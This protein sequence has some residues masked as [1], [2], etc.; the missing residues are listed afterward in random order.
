[1]RGVSGNHRGLDI[2]EQPSWARL[3]RLVENLQEGIC[4]GHG[5]I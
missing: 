3:L 5:F 1:M 2:E 4:H